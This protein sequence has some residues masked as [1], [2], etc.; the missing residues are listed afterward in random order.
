MFAAL[1]GLTQGMGAEVIFMLT[2]WK[3]Y[4]WLTLALAGIASAVTG[5]VYLWPIYY[6]GYAADLLLITGSQ[7]TSAAVYSHLLAAASSGALPRSGVTASYDRIV[8]LK[9]RL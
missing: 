4:D 2:G 7:A 3:R 1:A 6:V 8:A 5:F 9:G